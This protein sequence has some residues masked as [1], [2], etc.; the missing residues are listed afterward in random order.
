MDQHHWFN[1]LIQ[2]LNHIALVN[3]I[4]FKH[5]SKCHV[6]KMGAFGCK[7][8]KIFDDEVVSFPLFHKL[9]FFKHVSIFEVLVKGS[10][11]V[12]CFDVEKYSLDLADHTFRMDVS[13]VSMRMNTCSSHVHVIVVHWEVVFIDNFHGFVNTRSSNDC[14]CW[15]NCRNDVFDYS[16]SFM[17]INAFNIVF[18]SSFLCF[19]TNPLHIIRRISVIFSIRMHFFPDFDHGI[20]DTMLGN[21]RCLSKCTHRNMISI[22]GKR[23]LSAFIASR[24]ER[25]NNSR[26]ATKSFSSTIY[27]WNDRIHINLL[28]F[29]IKFYKLVNSLVNECSCF[30]IV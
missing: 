22:L 14:V 1:I 16:K 27:E 8:F 30:N 24:N 10:R 3:H 6:E 17:I 2:N 26:L 23:H 9:G 7:R 29:R 4:F 12:C 15:S 13:S 20:H 21:S 25:Q 18:L 5:F 11:S 28:C 19:F